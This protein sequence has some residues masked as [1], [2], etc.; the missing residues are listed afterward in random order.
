[1]LH[2]FIEYSLITLLGL[3]IGSFLNVVIVRLPVMLQQEWR[4]QYALNIPTRKSIPY[5]PG[6]YGKSNLELA[7]ITLSTPSSHCTHCR[8]AIKPWHN[9][10]VLS[11]I[12]LQGRCYHCHHRIAWRYPVIEIL[13]AAISVLVIYQL[14]YNFNGYCGLVFSW[15]LIALTAIDI[16]H[17]L[18]PD[19]LTITLLWVGLLVNINHLFTPLPDAVASAAGGYLVLWITIKIFYLITGKIGM[20]N[21]DFKLFAALGAWFGWKL[22]PYILVT[23]SFLGAVIGYSILKFQHRSYS[24]PIPFGPFLAIAGFIALL[25]GRGIA[26]T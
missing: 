24:T 18:L 10:P 12:M 26:F 5:R 17:Q 6:K 23:A 21:G 25:W 7:P 3:C 2:S 16:D 8:K 1:M 20:G 14:G 13:T 15:F 11:F 22:L 19:E 4:M 9:I